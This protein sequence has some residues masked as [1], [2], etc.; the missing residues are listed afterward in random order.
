MLKAIIAVDKNFGFA[1]DNSLPWPYIKEDMDHFVEKTKGK[2]VVMGKKTWLSDMPTPLPNRKNIVIT[3]EPDKLHDDGYLEMNLEEFYDY[4]N[5]TDEEI[6]VIGG[7]HL[8]E[9][10][11]GDVSEI[12]VT[13]IMKEFDC[14]IKLDIDKLLAKFHVSD[15]NIYDTAVGEIR[16]IQN[17]RAKSESGN[18]I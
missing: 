2:T 3:S 7:K 13:V 5:N 11:I 14:D 10:L 9:A 1:K 12:Y 18:C 4:A 17:V 8:I 6:W 15:Y 16:I